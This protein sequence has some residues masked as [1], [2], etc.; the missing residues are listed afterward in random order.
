MRSRF[1]P[2]S[3]SERRHIEST[4][5]T[6]QLRLWLYVAA[7]LLSI[8][9]PAKTFTS[10]APLNVHFSISSPSSLLNSPLLPDAATPP[11]GLPKEISLRKTERQLADL[12]GEIDAVAAKIVA[13]KAE[14]KK[15]NADDKPVNLKSPA[16]TPSSAPPHLLTAPPAAAAQGKNRP[17]IALPAAPTAT[18]ATAVVTAASA[19]SP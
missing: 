10:F 16:T 11:S 5:P 4:M 7:V 3:L 14:R 8:L 17:F 12:N 19:C 13:E 15:A 1:F 9:D 18:A 2:P 6:P